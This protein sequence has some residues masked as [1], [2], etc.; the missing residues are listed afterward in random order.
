MNSH[1]SFSLLLLAVMLLIGGQRTYG[2]TA[3]ITGRVM[4]QNAA[5]V[6][7]TEISITNVE[8]GISRKAVTNDEGYYSVPLLQPGGYRLTAQKPGFKPVARDNVTLAVG[9]TARLD[10]MLEAGNVDEDVNVVEQTPLLSPETSSLGQVIDGKKI[11]NIPLNGRSPFRLVQLTPGVLSSNSANG[12]FGDIPVNTTF[13]S[14][15]SING[16]RSQSNEVT[17]DGVPATAG[18]FNQITTIPSVEAAQEFKVESN[19]VAAEYGRFGGG[20]INV[21]TRSGGKEVH[22]TL[23]EFLRNDAFDANDFFNNRAGRQKPP[24]RMNQFGGSISGPVWLPRSVFGPASYDGRSQTFFFADYQGT[25]WRRGDVFFTTVPTE[26]ERRGD[27]SQTRDAQGR[28]VV[29]YDPLTTRA[30]PN[31]NAA[32]AISATN[33]PFIRTPF[34]GNII[35]PDRLDPIARAIIQY[36]PLPN[37]QG[38]QFTNINNFASNAK[39]RVDGDQYSARVDHN[40]GERYRTFVRFSR[41]KSALTQPDYFNNVASPNPG[42]VG[43]TPFLQHT[44]AN[45]HTVTINPTT[46]LNFRYGYARWFQSRVTRSFGFDQTSLGFPAALVAQQQVPVFPLITAEGNSNLG[47]QSFFRNGNDTHSLLGSLTKLAGKHALKF[48][49]DARLR[50]INFFDVNAAGGTY[51][52]TRSLTGIDSTVTVSNAGNAIAS[53]LLGAGSGGSTPVNGAA[54]LQNYYVAG[55]AQDDFK[56]T[57]KLT[58][59]LGLRYEVESPYTERYNRLASFDP[60]LPSPARNAQFPN[61]TGGLVYASDDERHVYDWD[62]NNWGLR[63]GFAYSVTPKTVVRGGA[64]VFFSPLEV[65]NNAV[66]FIPNPGFSAS[67]PWQATTG[68]RFVFRPLRDPYPQGLLQP[69]GSSLGASTFISQGLNLWDPN[70]RT[71][72]TMQWNLNLQRELPWALLLDVAYAGNRGVRL[73]RG[74]ELNALDPQYLARGNSLTATQTNPFPLGAAAAAT[75]T[76]RQLLLPFPQFTSVN[77]IN[78]TAGNSVYH[79][80]QA[81]V[82]KPLSGGVNFLLAYTFSKLISDVNN[83]LAPIGDLTNVTGVQNF[84]D[85]RAERA[86]SEMDRTH[87]LAFSYV[88]ELPFGTGRRYFNHARGV[89]GLAL[90]GWQ[91]NGVARYDSGVPLS[92]AAAITGGGNRPNWTGLSAK[93]DSDRPRGEQILRWFDTGVQLNPAL[94]CAAP[95][96][97]C[98]PPA[99]SFGNAPRTFSGVRGPAY[100]NVDVSLIKMTRLSEAVN[101]QFRSEFFNV[102]NI[103]NFALPNTNIN[104]QQYGQIN[105]ASALPRVIQFALKLVF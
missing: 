41:N 10:F 5:V 63:F 99:F 7:G 39:R 2:Q 94:P 82:D 45:D 12:Q 21:S 54:S 8:T 90:E 92:F 101:L 49:V 69:V 64:G 78:N 44:V 46:I 31:Y 40:F 43:T 24:F 35:P 85:L 50:R 18:F 96:V 67:T 68:G 72:Y 61:I 23:Y 6:Q 74:R 28:L 93:L 37:N 62:L 20:I 88:V 42:A 86:V 79:A 9:Q 4:D 98:Q 105:A 76:Q 52:F 95:A 51:N 97:F 57:S 70:A 19:N 33:T 11:V 25:R 55:Y 27:F 89:R 71:P 13:D 1:S 104:S 91:I 100:R 59:N 80:W 81:K 103:A 65:S 14:N 84:Y 3:E 36:Y 83:Q 53:F 30:N 38:Q 47:G 102:F 16:G 29:I 48:G 15:F 60:T 22:G 73:T 56:V 66:G 17:I 32:Q 87:S 75:V 34:A 77:L 58:L 26:L